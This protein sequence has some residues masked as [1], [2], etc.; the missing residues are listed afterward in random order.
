VIFAEWVKSSTATN[1][2]YFVCQL[3]LTL[4]CIS[5]YF[6]APPP[7]KK[8]NRGWAHF[9]AYTRRSTAHSS[10][11]EHQCHVDSWRRKRN[12]ELLLPWPSFWPESVIISWLTWKWVVY[13]ITVLVLYCVQDADVKLFDYQRPYARQITPVKLSYVKKVK[14]AHTRLPSVGFRIWSRFLAV[15]LQVTW[16]TNPAVVCH[17]FSA[18]P[19]VTPASRNPKEGGYQ[20]RCLMNRGTMGIMLWTVCLRLLPDSVAAMIWTQALLRLSPAR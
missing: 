5:F 6:Q 11:C 14:V 3:V 4:R 10:K 15:S 17:I 2:C 20:F 12:T 18:W 7:P 16:V 1:F 8:K 19:T 13:I 9:I